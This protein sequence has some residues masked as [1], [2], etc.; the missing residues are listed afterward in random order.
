VIAAVAAF[1][2]ASLPLAGC[3]SDAES[4]PVKV[5]DAKIVK[6][7]KLQKSDGDFQI[8]DD[9]SCRVSENLLND[10]DEV[11]KARKDKKTAA[12]VVEAPAGGFGVVGL[13][14]FPPSC[15]E[16]AEADL[17]HVKVPKQ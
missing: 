15:G 10:A 5:A 12:L 17:A 14:I 8:G 4:K 13:P 16:K 3:G 1:A 7:L 6:A 2:L 11:A 9:T